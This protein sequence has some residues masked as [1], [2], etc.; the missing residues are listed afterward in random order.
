MAILRA[1]AALL[2]RTERE[3]ERVCVCVCVCVYQTASIDTLLSMSLN[4][5]PLYGTM[6]CTSPNL[7]AWS[8]LS[9]DML[10]GDASSSTLWKASPHI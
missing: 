2:G 8:K 1:S 7:V 10:G 6:Y 4:F 3:R 5:S 9:S